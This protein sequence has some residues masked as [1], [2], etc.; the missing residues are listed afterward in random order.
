MSSNVDHVIVAR[1]LSKEYK[2]SALQV[3]HDTLR[4]HLAYGWKSLLRRNRCEP[5]SSFWALKDV[6]FTVKQGEVVGIIG[7][8]GAGKSTLLKVLSRITHPTS[9]S[10]LIRGRVASLL[11]VGTGFQPELSG[12]DNIYLSG[13][14]LGMRKSDINRRFDEIVDFSG[15][16]PFIDTPVKRYSSGMYV[17]LA[18]AVAAHL[19]PD[20]MFIDEV[21]AVG[22]VGFQRKCLAKMEHEARGGRT[23]LFVSHNLAAVNSLCQRVLLLSDG[24]VKCEGPSGT[25]ISR[26]IAQFEN[27][28]PRQQRSKIEPDTNFADTVEGYFLHPKNQDVDI[29]VPCGESITIEFELESP[30]ILHELTAGIVIVSGTDEKIVGMSSKVQNIRSISAPS[31]FWSVRCEI[32]RLPLNAGDYFAHVYIGNGMIDVARFTRGFAIR[33]QEH[34]VFGW[35]NRLPDKIAWGPMYWAPTWR[36]ASCSETSVPGSPGS[37]P[38]E[39]TSSPASIGG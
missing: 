12:R 19:E 11:E 35:G 5:D 7:Q 21:L 28:S 6:S 32:G 31:R 2:L 8:N 33:V 9:G 3:R 24:R 34:D 25:V 23:I 27:D 13:A 22:D 18:F 16:E 17:R 15:I 4:D 38:E 20:I 36:I 14:I 26:Y 39:N 10:V 1:E 37:V 30:K 29:S